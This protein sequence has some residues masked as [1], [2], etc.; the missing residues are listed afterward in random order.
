MFQLTTSKTLLY[1]DFADYM[2]QI[3]SGLSRDQA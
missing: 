1:P 2:K 3:T